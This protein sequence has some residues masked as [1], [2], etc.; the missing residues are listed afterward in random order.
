MYDT[1]LSLKKNYRHHVVNGV[2]SLKALDYHVVSDEEIIEDTE[3]GGQFTAM[4][5]NFRIDINHSLTKESSLEEAVKQFEGLKSRVNKI[6]AKFSPV[7]FIQKMFRGYRVR[8]R[9]KYMM[10]TREW[11]ATSIQRFYRC[12]KGITTC[13]EDVLPPPSSPFHGDTSPMT[14]HAA[15][16]FGHDSGDDGG[17]PEKSVDAGLL[18]AQTS[19]SSSKAKPSSIYLP[20]CNTLS[21]HD[22][23]R[24]R[25]EHLRFDSQG[26]FSGSGR[27]LSGSGRNLSGSNRNLEHRASG[28]MVG[29]NSS[30]EY[31]DS[32]G[33]RKNVKKQMTIDLVKLEAYV[34]QTIKSATCTVSVGSS[35]EL[36]KQ[37]K[38]SRSKISINEKQISEN[39]ILE[40]KEEIE[41]VDDLLKKRRLKP[42]RVGK[43]RTVRGFLGPILEPQTKKEVT[44]LVTSSSDDD[45][46]TG[47]R[48]RGVTPPRQKNEPVVEML[49]S[50]KEMGED[51]RRALREH[52]PRKPKKAV[53]NAP[54]L[55]NDQK[56]FMRTHG[57]MGMACLRA[58]H[59]AYGDRERDQ[60]QT[61]KAERVAEMKERREQVKGRLRT[62]KNDFQENVL[63]ERIRDG[64]RIA[65]A[66]RENE[67]KQEQEH[68]KVSSRRA[69]AIMEERARQSDATFVREFV[70]QQTS[71]SQALGAHDQAELKKEKLTKLA[72]TV[73]NER[74]STLEQQALVRRYMEHRQLQRQAE[75]A[76]AKAEINARLLQEA[77][78]RYMEIQTR[79]KQTKNRNA[80][81]KEFYPLPPS[82]APTIDTPLSIL[83][84][85]KF[86]FWEESLHRD[87][88][89][90]V[91]DILSNS[92]ICS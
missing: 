89:Y 65:D 45:E 59:Q 90:L 75:M 7:L 70:S 58:V 40:P 26:N 54:K 3:M 64:V 5:N 37:G 68:E 22:K 86:R 62:I 44:R 31:E 12:Y 6:Q 41:N 74:E 56:L 92:D 66:L 83:S 53:R 47:F 28:E 33:K 61:N 30:H 34:M 13:R 57:T 46:T 36:E 72:E 24:S 55:N 8:R 1:P 76:R 42:D 25:N 48:L 71:V 78:R 43:Y 60:R 39:T 17:G 79:A 81:V 32:E 52:R 63:R 16:Y 14:G 2:W 29:E 51:I 21:G 23:D 10:A 88:R 20:I 19:D 38:D 35:L 4:Q 85:A 9:Y 49:L 15:D 69:T 77:N 50:R 27:N 67:K 18:Q 73:R 87:S 82:N 80:Q 84:P 91:D 11:A